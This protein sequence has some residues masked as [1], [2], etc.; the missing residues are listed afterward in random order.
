MSVET[1]FVDTNVLVY[2]FGA[3]APNKQARARELRRNGRDCLAVSVQ[4]PGE[5]YVTVTRKLAK[6]LTPDAAAQVVE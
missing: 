2:L 5:F 1:K 6:P 4:V 3:D